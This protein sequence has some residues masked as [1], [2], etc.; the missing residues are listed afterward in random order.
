MIVE[1]AQNC[2]SDNPALSR[3]GKPFFILVAAIA[4]GVL[5]FLPSGSSAAALLITSERE[6]GL[7]K[8]VKIPEGFEATIFAAAPAVNYPVFVAAAPDGTLFVSSDKNGSLDR[9]PHR[10]RVLRVRDLDGDGH[11]DEVKEF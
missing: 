4:A 1:T 5:L 10:G 6:Q 9:G 8:E 11:A 2:F 7:L 3:A